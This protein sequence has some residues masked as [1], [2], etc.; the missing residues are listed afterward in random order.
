MI[1]NYALSA[2]KV[3]EALKMKFSKEMRIATRDVHELSDKL[4]NMKLAL[5]RCLKEINFGVLRIL[6]LKQFL[7]KI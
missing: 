4:V 1:I 6:G 3:I 2:R 7:F 5:G